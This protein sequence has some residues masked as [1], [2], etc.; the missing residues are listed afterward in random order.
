MGDNTL[1]NIEN[2]PDVAVA[3]ITSN[4]KA[5]HAEENPRAPLAQDSDSPHVP[6][7]QKGTEPAWQGVP[8]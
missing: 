1:V 6:G 3:P 8:L 7:E 5:G 4:D 2:R